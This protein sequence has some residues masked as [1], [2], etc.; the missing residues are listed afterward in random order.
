[1]S[2][3]NRTATAVSFKFVLIVA[4]VLAAIGCILVF[5]GCAFEAQSQLNL[6]RASGPAALDAYLAHVDSHQLSFAA[7][8]FASVSGHGYAYGAF[9]QGVGFWFVFV[10]APLSAPLLIAARWLAARDRKV[11]LR[12]RFAAAH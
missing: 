8:M 1:M 2:N 12:L 3:R 4:A 7:Y 6:L 10:L 5:S 9:L 11:N